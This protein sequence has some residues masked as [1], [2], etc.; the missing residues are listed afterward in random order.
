MSDDLFACLIAIAT[1]DH[2]NWILKLL[3]G[4]V[5]HS[6]IPLVGR[7]F[8]FDAMR[9]LEGTGKGGDGGGAK[10]FAFA[11]GKEFQRGSRRQS[12]G[13]INVGKRVNGAGTLAGAVRGGA[14]RPL[15]VAPLAAKSG[16]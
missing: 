6:D 5:Y 14:G 4:D 13:A 9:M 8:T 16:D 11:L 2:V 10:G 1:Y 7:G 15:G 3:Q 12:F